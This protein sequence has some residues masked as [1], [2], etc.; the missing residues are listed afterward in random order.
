M[1][2]GGGFVKRNIYRAE[3]RRIWILV[4]YRIGMEVQKT[5]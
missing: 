1:G 5:F 4:E 2:L 3:A